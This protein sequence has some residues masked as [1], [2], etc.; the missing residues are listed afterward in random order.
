V[1]FADRVGLWISVSG[2]TPCDATVDDLVAGVFTAIKGGRVRHVTYAPDSFGGIEPCSLITGPEFATLAGATVPEAEPSG[3]SCSYGSI[4]LLFSIGE[5]SSGTR[6]MV[7]GRQAVVEQTGTA[8]CVIIFERP[9]ADRPGLVEVA[10][11]YGK[12]ARGCK[13]GRPA[14]E[15]VGPK[16]PR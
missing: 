1:T 5:P 13:T 6:E 8:I 12:D 2:Q 4:G 7:G 11:V 9:L 3:H 15:L 16:L 10:Q 14:A